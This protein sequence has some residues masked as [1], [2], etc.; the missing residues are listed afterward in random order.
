MT[1]GTYNFVSVILNVAFIGAS[2]LSLDSTGGSALGLTLL[3]FCVVISVKTQFSVHVKIKDISQ[4]IKGMSRL[5]QKLFKY[6]NGITILRF[7]LVFVF[8]CSVP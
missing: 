5:S 6:F 4:L 3:V 1:T 2:V 7:F 8:P